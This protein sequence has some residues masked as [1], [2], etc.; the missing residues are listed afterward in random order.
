LQSATIAAEGKTA[1][2]DPRLGG[3]LWFFG[4]VW[5]DVPGR[6][7]IAARFAD[8]H[9]ARVLAGRAERVGR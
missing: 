5:G 7:E 4:F 8:R 1:E 9:P 6:V 3:F 2:F